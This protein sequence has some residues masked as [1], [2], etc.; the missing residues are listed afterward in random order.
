M[1]SLT[2]QFQKTIMKSKNQDIQF[3]KQLK[4]QIVKTIQITG[5]G[6]LSEE[7]IRDKLNSNQIEEFQCQGILT[8]TEEARKKK[9]EITDRHNQL[10]Q[11]EQDLQEMT[12][13]FNETMEYVKLQGVVIEAIEQKVEHAREDVN[14][15]TEL[16]GE[17]KNLWNKAWSNKKI[18]GILM[19]SLVLLLLIV[20]I[21]TS[22]TS[23]DQQPSSTK[24]EA[25]SSSSSSTEIV[26][27]PSTTTTSKDDRCDPDD[28]FCVG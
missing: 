17:A 9:E 25:S 5:D 12:D 23:T 10:K 18:L 11:L 14:R 1:K 3:E 22:D 7:E 8:E 24:T 2:E 15:G 27:T 4:D 28:P 26:T 20:I 21:A 19:A 6:K 13:L 16:L